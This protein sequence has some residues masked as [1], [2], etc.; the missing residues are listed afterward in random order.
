[1]SFK[2]SV[3]FRPNVF[4]HRNSLINSQLDQ[5]FFGAHKNGATPMITTK[6]LF[7]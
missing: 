5:S 6:G 7:Y 2:I 3:I 1:M 4:K